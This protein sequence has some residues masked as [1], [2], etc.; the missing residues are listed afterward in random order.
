MEDKLNEQETEMSWIIIS[1]IKLQTAKTE[2]HLRDQIKRE[3]D[4]KFAD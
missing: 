2:K 3:I 1:T 4:M